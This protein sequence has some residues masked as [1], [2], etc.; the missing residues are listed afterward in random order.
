MGSGASARENTDIHTGVVGKGMTQADWGHITKG[1]LRMWTRISIIWAWV[2]VGH[3]QGQRGGHWAL[4]ALVPEDT[5]K[6][7]DHRC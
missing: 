6:G 1:C 5:V 2:R 7:H 4:V 3:R